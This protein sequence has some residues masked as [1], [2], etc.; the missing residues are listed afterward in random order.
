MKMKKSELYRL[1]QIAVLSASFSENM[2]LEV[3][4]ALMS[5]EDM[6][7]LLEKRE[8]EKEKA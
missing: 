5:D 7:K 1:A 2:K 4:K 6:A 8:D 3:L